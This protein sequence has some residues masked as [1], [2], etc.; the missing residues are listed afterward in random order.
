[1]N[2]VFCG[3]KDGSVPAFKVFEDEKTVAFMDINPV[4]DGHLLVIPKSHAENLFDL[5]EDDLKAVASAVQQ[6]AR[7]VKAALNPDGMNL[8]QANGRAAFQSVPHF[9]IHVVPRW[10]NDG[11]GLDWELVRGDFEKIKSVAETIKAQ[12]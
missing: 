3:V 2:C 7:A 12:I 11:K 5:S 10:E 4:N 9:H 1:M 8:L 6:V